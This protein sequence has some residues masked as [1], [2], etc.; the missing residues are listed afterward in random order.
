MAATVLD[1]LDDVNLLGGHFAGS[2]WNTWRCVLRAA[3]ALPLSPT[4]LQRFREVAGGRAPP[5]K[6]VRELVCAVGRSGGK[7]AIASALAVW[8]ATTC[9]TGKLRAGE[10]ADVLCFA[11]DREQSGIAFTYIRELFEDVPLLRGMVKVRNKRLAITEN[12]IELTNRARITVGTNNRRSPRGKTIAAAIYDEVGFWYSE[13]YANPD[14]ETDVAVSPGLARFP[15][16]LKIMISSVNKR[17]GLLYDR[18]S[19][20]FGKDDPDTLVVTGTSL[21]FNPALDSKIID[22]ELERD[23]E[24]AAAEYLSRWR[25][26]LSLFIDRALIE[27][28]VDRDCLVRSPDG[29]FRAVAFADAS[30]GRGDSFALAIAHR[31]SDGHYVLDQLW[32]KVPPFNVE[33]AVYEACEILRSYNINRVT[34]DKYAIGFTEAAFRRNGISYQTSEKDKSAL[35]LEALPLFTTGRVR[36]LDNK[37]LVQQFTSLERRTSP[38][39]KDSVSHP[40][41]RNSHDDLSNACAGALVLCSAQT[42]LV[43]SD[44]MLAAAHAHVSPGSPA[45]NARHG[46][47]SPARRYGLGVPALF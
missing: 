14:V 5:Q 32:E 19:R 39:G 11:T 30:S 47:S 41:H 35:Y 22:R 16:S 6:P 7:D 45:W 26:D 2:S 8:I 4:E 25:D 46:Y 31:T 18:F 10:R 28:A 29:R 27:G 37:K 15:G 21:D 3:F 12:T 23:P 44:E 13:N 20:Y 36:L 1:F 38:I 9:D 34:G 33:D 42:Q 24:R 17:A 43:I 40:D